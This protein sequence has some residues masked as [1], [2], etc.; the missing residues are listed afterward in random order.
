[1]SSPFELPP[2]EMPMPEISA[3]SVTPSDAGATCEHAPPLGG[4]A[5]R[6]YHRAPDL[7][8]V[9]LLAAVFALGHHT[10]WKMPKASELWTSA[11]AGG[12]DWCAEHLISESQCIECQDNLLPRPPAFGFCRLH[13]VAECVNCHPFLAQVHGEPAALQYDPAAALMVLDRPENN[14]RNMLHKRR[15]QFA[16]AESVQRAGVEVDVVEEQ[17]MQ[18]VLIANGEVIFDPTA[19]G[20]FVVALRGHGLACL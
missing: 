8:V 4:L 13:G 14:S 5:R 18:D 20:A 6:W 19:R 2:T 1:M 3:P 15:V 12:D 10:G 9:A 11:P 16:S 17:P 7:L